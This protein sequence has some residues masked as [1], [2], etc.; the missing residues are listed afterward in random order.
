MSSRRI[1]G[2]D[3][4]LCI[5]CSHLGNSCICGLRTQRLHQGT[6][7]LEGSTWLL[8]TKRRES[9]ERMRCKSL[10]HQCH[11]HLYKWRTI[12]HME[13]KSLQDRPY[14]KYSHSSSLQRKY[15]FLSLCLLVDILSNLYPKSTISN[16]LGH[17]GY[18]FRKA[19]HTEMRVPGLP[20]SQLF[21]I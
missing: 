20:Q 15:F 4:P 6:L 1:L 8:K 12:H 18:M 2:T 11:P 9:P 14:Q 7:D 5:Y 13:S 10:C 19:I 21:C 16:W 3:Q 17:L